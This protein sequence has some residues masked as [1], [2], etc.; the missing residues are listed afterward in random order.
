M[1]TF[2]GILAFELQGGLEAATTFV[3]QL[4]LCTL[5]P[6]LGDIDTLIMH[7]A[8]MSNAFVAKEV[9]EAQGITDGLIRISVGV[10]HIS[11]ILAD[12]SQSLEGL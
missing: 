7:P 8:S 2:G 4:Q 5:A 9:R 1:R 11:D 3:Q 12:V 6:T 10:E